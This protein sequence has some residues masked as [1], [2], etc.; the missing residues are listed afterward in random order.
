MTTIARRATQISI[1]SSKGKIY[2][3]QV[4][5]TGTIDKGKKYDRQNNKI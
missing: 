2:D 3:D 5:L 1:S 4:K